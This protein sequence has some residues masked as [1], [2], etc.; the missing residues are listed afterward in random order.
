MKKGTTGEASIHVEAPPEKV[1]E[2]VTDVRRMGEWSPECRSC[3]WLDGATEPAVG[4]RFRGSNRNGFARWSTKPRVVAA[5]EG[6]EFAF[7][8]DFRKQDTTKWRYRFEPDG[9]GTKVIESFEMMHDMP[10]VIVFLEKQVMRVKDRRAD[11]VR[12]MEA[13]L[14]RIKAV[15]EGRA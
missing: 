10:G 11:L 3:E 15:A 14:E 4:A 13:T 9:T 5:D 8:V 1:Y 6:R 2:L 12:N 7:V